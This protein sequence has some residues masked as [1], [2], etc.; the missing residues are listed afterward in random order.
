[1]NREEKYLA[2]KKVTLIGAATN[3]LLS[4][5]KMAA[6]IFG[7]SEALIADAVHSLSDLVSDV[8]VLVSLKVSQRPVDESRP[9]GYGKVETV[10]TGI[11]GLILIAVAIEMFW[12]AVKTI[13]EGVSSVPT[14]VALAGAF[15]SILANELLF[16]Y[17]IKVGRRVHSPSILANAWHHRSDALSS[18]AALAGAGAAMMGWPIFDPIAAL[19]VTVLI[20]KVGWEIISESF[21]DIIDT[22]V[23]KEILDQIINAVIATEGAIDF[24]D[25]KTR[26]MGSDIL[27]DIHIEVDSRLTVYDAH[28]IADNVRDNIV[29][30]VQ[31]VADVLVHLDPGDDSGSIVYAIPEKEVMEEVG[32][33]AESVDEVI[34]WTDI[35]F[36]YD[37][38]SLIVS[39]SV[40]LKPELTIS[41]AYDVVD[42]IKKQVTTIDRV[43]NAIITI[44]MEKGEKRNNA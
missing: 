15:F 37:D 43:S 35:N 9:Y 34:G 28:N 31:H 11:L 33:A 7:R 1:M 5:L 8:V 36:K 6:G 42:N 14:G 30:K 40:T 26:K 18:V 24:H 10:G 4:I 44:D 23:K 25:L 12:D 27:V 21:K 29:E 20:L 22:A 19:I 39:L 41:E 17:S 38:D 3:L 2:G 16:R 32:H 13:N